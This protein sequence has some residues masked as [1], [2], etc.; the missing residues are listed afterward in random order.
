MGGRC[1]RAPCTGPWREG[2]GVLVTGLLTIPYIIG[3][4]TAAGAWWKPGLPIDHLAQP[5]LHAFH[6]YLNPLHYTR[7]TSSATRT[8]YKL[9]WRC[10]ESRCGSAAGQLLFT[11]AF[12]WSACCR[13]RLW[14]TTR[15]FPVLPMAGWSLYAAVLL[16]MAR[17]LLVSLLARLGRLQGGGFRWYP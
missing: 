5:L 1:A 6:L 4:L 13:L 9:L 14:P 15:I 17:R 11:C 3:K 7:S 16:V 10:W 12:C 2:R 8:P